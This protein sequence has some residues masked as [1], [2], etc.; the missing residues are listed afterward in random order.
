LFAQSKRKLSFG[1][2]F[3]RSTLEM[4]VTVRGNEL[5]NQLTDPY[6]A[7]DWAENVSAQSDF[8]VFSQGPGLKYSEKAEWVNIRMKMFSQLNN[9]TTTELGLLMIYRK[10]CHKW[11]YFVASMQFEDI[12]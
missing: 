2:Q 11:I 4:N 3:A 10:R 7:M 1:I 9:D 5:L 6:P 12:H 8:M